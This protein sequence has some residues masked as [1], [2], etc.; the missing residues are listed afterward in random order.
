MCVHMSKS[1]G[2]E[3]LVIKGVEEETTWDFVL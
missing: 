3:T 1:K 2:S